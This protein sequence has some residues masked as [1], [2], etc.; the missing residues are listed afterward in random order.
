[1][2]TVTVLGDEDEH[3][4]YRKQQGYHENFFCVL[5]GLCSKGKQEGGPRETTY[6]VS[7]SS[8]VAAVVGHSSSGLATW[9]QSPSRDASIPLL[10]S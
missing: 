7:L 2:M 5:K 9:M 3:M 10:V 1:M 6:G 8:I 4:I